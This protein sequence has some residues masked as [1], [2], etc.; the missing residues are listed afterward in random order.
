[1]IP[2][3]DPGLELAEWPLLDLLAGLWQFAHAPDGV[4]LLPFACRLG[5]FASH[6]AR[7][8]QHWTELHAQWTGDAMANPHVVLGYEPDYH[9][10][11]LPWIRT[12][13]GI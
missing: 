6:F 4:V 8:P 7:K 2:L 13:K 9:V 5:A 10:A 1:L 12:M 11:L 3:M